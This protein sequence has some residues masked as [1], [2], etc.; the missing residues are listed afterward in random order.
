MEIL[1]NKY[2]SSVLTLIVVLYATFLRPELPAN[3]K[4]TIKDL[5]NN[6]IFRIFVLFLVVAFGNTSPSLAL[7]IAIAFVLTMDQIYVWDSKEAFE[8]VRENFFVDMPADKNQ[9]HFHIHHSEEPC[10]CKNAPRATRATHAPATMPPATM[11]QETMAPATMAPATMAPA[12][13]AQATMP[14]AT[15]APATLSKARAFQSKSRRL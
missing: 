6:T 1:E 5:F 7:I 13:M 15:M 12:T 2:V 10:D 3:I 9:I 4:D 11:P 8:S 14:P